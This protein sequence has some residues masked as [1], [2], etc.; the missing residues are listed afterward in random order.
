[1]SNSPLDPD[2]AGLLLGAPGALVAFISLVRSAHSRGARVLVSLVT[3]LGFA[4]LG[5]QTPFLGVLVIV[6]VLAGSS[7]GSPPPFIRPCAL[8]SQ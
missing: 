5:F 4:A 3:L 8:V 6:L 7:S 1:M 2:D